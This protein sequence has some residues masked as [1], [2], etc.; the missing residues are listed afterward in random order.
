MGHLSAMFK[1]ARSLSMRKGKN[2]N[3]DRDGRD[4]AKAMEKEAKKNELILR[5]SGCVHVT[6]SKNLASL[7]SKRGEKGVNQDCFIFWEVSTLI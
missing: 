7:F 3:G 2:F 4:T 6:G 5:S 1:L